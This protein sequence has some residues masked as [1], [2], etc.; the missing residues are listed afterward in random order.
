M[1]G[2]DEQKPIRRD[3]LKDWIVL[4]VED[5]PGNLDVAVRIL[6]F[7]G[8]NAH[9]ATNGQEALALLATLHPRFI[10]SDLSMPVMSG[11]DLIKHLKR[12]QR[13]VDIPTIA[14]TAHTM[15]GDREK[16]IAAGFNKYLTKPL[17]GKTFMRELLALLVDIPGFA[18]ELKR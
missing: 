14:L 1:S 3:I 5:D 15:A 7:Y 17:T 6:R 18:S 13:W 9:S 8:A 10:I 12:E 4:V 16:A 2:A 11:W